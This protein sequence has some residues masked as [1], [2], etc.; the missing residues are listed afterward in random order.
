MTS[1]FTET[2]ARHDAQARA[3]W[4]LYDASCARCAAWARRF[5][6]PLRRRGFLIAPLQSLWVPAALNLSTE[7]LLVEMRVLTADGRVLGGADAMIHLAEYIWW[8]RPLHWL[9]QVPEV[10][11]LLCRVYRWVAAHR[12][13]SARGCSIPQGGTE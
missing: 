12:H 5:R 7:E 4:V 11:G 8:A 10:R 9:A 3:A 13:C 6:A 2:T 1:V